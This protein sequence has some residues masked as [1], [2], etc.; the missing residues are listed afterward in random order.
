MSVILWVSIG[1]KLKFYWQRLNA[2]RFARTS[3]VKLA[4]QYFTLRTSQWMP[5]FSLLKMLNH[6]IKLLW[7]RH[8][9]QLIMWIKVGLQN[10]CIY[11]IISCTLHLTWD[12][13]LALTIWNLWWMPISQVSNRMLSLTKNY[14]NNSFQIHLYW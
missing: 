4:Q 10:T 6:K 9:Q 7:N 2:K 1:C 8:N 11:L 14:I 5:L 12:L 3:F 13:I